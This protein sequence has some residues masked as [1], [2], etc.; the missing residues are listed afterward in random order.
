MDQGPIGSL[1]WMHVGNRKFGQQWVCGGIDMHNATSWGLEVVASRW[2][3]QG[4]T[5]GYGSVGAQPTGPSS[6]GG[7]DIQTLQVDEIVSF[8]DI[9][10]LSGNIDALKEMTFFL[11]SILV[12]LEIITS[13]LQGESY[14]VVLQELEKR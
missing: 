9:G 10:G 3:H 6:K 2:G 5:F 1:S 11:F 4:D 14:Y 12:S 13:L 7:A 8:D